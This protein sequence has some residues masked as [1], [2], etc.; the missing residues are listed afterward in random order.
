MRDE[1][2][3]GE[4]L[5]SL[6]FELGDGFLDRVRGGEVEEVLV[7]QEGFVECL[8]GYFMV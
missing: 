4:V 5:D 7:F 8:L 3:G 2:V 6:L 1:D